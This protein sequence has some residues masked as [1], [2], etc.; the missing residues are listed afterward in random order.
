[1]IEDCGVTEEQ[2]AVE[3]GSEVASIVAEVSDPP[4]VH[5]V[6]AKEI[7]LLKAASLSHNA[8]RLKAADRCSNL[9]SIYETPPGWANT[10]YIGYA[11]HSIRMMDLFEKS[12]HE[13]LHNAVTS[14][15]RHWARLIITRAE[16]EIERS[17]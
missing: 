9:R 4:G 1:M 13:P 5:G 17:A 8:K 3:F 6:P 12:G 2:L 16:D 10:S 14:K 15:V 11:D 7:Q